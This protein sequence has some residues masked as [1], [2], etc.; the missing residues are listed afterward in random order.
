MR[1]PAEK[2]SLAAA[3]TP[4]DDEA[5]AAPMDWRFGCCWAGGVGSGS[6]GIIAADEED[7]RS[8]DGA[9]DAGPRSSLCCWEKPGAGVAG[10]ITSLRV[11][12]ARPR[13]SS[14]VDQCD[15]GQ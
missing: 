6:E 3:D 15:I 11:M 1:G 12:L 2:P 9:A 5:A 14:C 10:D 8:D 13:D 4:P 7:A